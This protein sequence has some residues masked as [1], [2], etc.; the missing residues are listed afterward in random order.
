MFRLRIAFFTLGLAI[1]LFAVRG[2]GQR[3]SPASGVVVDFTA[4]PAIEYGIV[5]SLQR[6]PDSPETRIGAAI[7][8]STV[9]LDRIGASG[10]HYI[11]GRVIVKFKGGATAASRA[12]AMSMARAKATAQPSYANFDVITI[13][14]GDDA[15]AAAAALAARPDV[16]YAQPAYRVRTQCAAGWAPPDSSGHCV[17]NDRFY[18]NQWN[19]PDIDMERAWNIQPDAASQITVAVLDT[20]IA[21][22]NVTMRYH[23]NAFS[24]DSAG[25]VDVPPAPGGTP[26]PSLGNLTLQFVAA[27]ELLPSSRFVSPRDFIW[28]TNLPIDLDGHGTHVS[29]TIGQL[30]NNANSNIGDTAHGGGTAG[31]AFNVKL[32]PVKVIDSEWDDIFGAPNFGTDD[33]VARGIRYAADNGAKVIN[34]SIGRTGPRAPAVE[35]AMNYAVQKGAFIAVAAGNDYEDGNPTETYADAASRVQGAVS[36]GAVD[37][38]HNRAYYSSSGSYVEVAAP[39]G[40]FRGFSAEGGILQQTLDLQLV[41]TFT[42]SPADFARTPPRFDALAYY[43]FIGTSQATPHVSGAAAMLTQQGITS[44]PAIEAALEKFAT[45]LGPPGRDNDF[46]FGEINARNTLRGMGLVK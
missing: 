38:S 6:A 1:V 37:R 9:A 2:F 39:G 40:S 19:L 16:E 7:R 23:A 12:S 24:V 17:P 30:T 21:Y 42:L 46:G 5:P 36:V 10:A 35:D 41:A 4:L 13:D 3:S 32:M 33:L 25:N 45:D 28:D 18:T 20:G 22:T 31:V 14:P 29:G 8:T 34:M 43:Y 44:P 15:E 26:Y 11:A 27:T